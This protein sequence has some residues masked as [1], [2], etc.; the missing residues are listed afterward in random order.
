MENDWSY[1]IIDQLFYHKK[2]L[3][4]NI[5]D[6]YDVFG[7]SAGGQVAHRLLLFKPNSPMNKIVSSAS[8]WYTMP[9]LSIE[10]LGGPASSPEENNNLTELFNKNFHVMVGSLDNDP[11]ASGLRHTPEAELYRGSMIERATS[12]YITKVN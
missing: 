10:F 5:S 7:N 3:T 8:G 9:D 2:Q 6:T 4:N 11:S 12:F 1:S